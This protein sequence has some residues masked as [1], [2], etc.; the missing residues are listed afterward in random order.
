MKS[1]ISFF[2]RTLLRKDITRFSPVWIL[3]L[4]GG[5]MVGLS[6]VSGYTRDYYA[7]SAMAVTIGPLAVVNLFYALVVAECLFGDLFNSR[8]CN[9]IH[10]LPL[11]REKLFFTH[12]TAGMLFSLVPNTLF[13]LVL[14][15]QLGSFWYVALIWLLGMTL[16]Y[17]FFF[18]V[19]AVCAVSTGSRFAMGALYALINFL[20]EVIRWFV[21][22]FYEPLLPGLHIRTEGFDWFCPAVWMAQMEDLVIFQQ[23]KTMIDYH[24]VEV[25]AAT[26]FGG[27]SGDWWYLAALAG[28][29]VVLLGV[30]ILLYRKRQLESAGD[31]L[32]FRAMML[33]CS[34]VFTLS[35]AAVF[36]IV[37]GEILDMELAALLVGFVV[38]CFGIEM[39]LRRT[40]KVFDKRTCVKCALIGG[41]FALTLLLTMIDPLGVT[42]WTP[43]PEKVE[44]IILS[45]EY[46]YDPSDVRYPG[47]YSSMEITDPEKIAE[48]VQIHKSLIGEEDPHDYGV[49][50]YQ[51][52]GS[53]HLTYR[54]EDGRSVERRYYYLRDS[55]IGRQLQEYYGM[56]EFILGVQDWQ[57]FLD[58][59]KYVEVD[60]YRGTYEQIYG[61]RAIELLEA[62]KADCEAGNI[63]PETDY[64]DGQYILTIAADNVGRT[65][66][67]GSDAVNT[68]QWLKDYFADSLF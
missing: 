36:Q 39:L 61:T 46:D 59:V 58:V 54:M 53:F 48:L 64:E 20:S 14:M 21:I 6:V 11:R 49:Y 27:L 19:A 65:I 29:G 37:L 51:Y 38:G 66:Y 7:A 12:V 31:F 33:P 25:S 8:L 4:I 2:D 24:W 22:T 63:A 35:V 26:R 16:Q 47:Q 41:A 55:A 40:V 1:R 13:S 10:S 52:A 44:S 43:K 30:G 56:P 23:D 32:A 34:V 45:D 60:D 50:S 5:L 28:I 68:L 3:Y 62:V 18:A 15:P 42:R 57:G 67:I 9:A 17:L